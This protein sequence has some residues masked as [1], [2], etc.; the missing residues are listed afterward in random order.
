MV[1]P[2]L[3]TKKARGNPLASLS[4]IIYLSTNH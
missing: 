1:S 3:F 2:S 4:V